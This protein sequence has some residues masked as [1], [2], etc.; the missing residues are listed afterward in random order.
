MPGHRYLP[1]RKRIATPTVV[2][3][4]FLPAGGARGR[5]VGVPSRAV[6]AARS[7][8]SARRWTARKTEGNPSPRWRG[9]LRRVIT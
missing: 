1:G 7:R 4:E 2:H 6:S 9:A 8:E 3:G 5:G